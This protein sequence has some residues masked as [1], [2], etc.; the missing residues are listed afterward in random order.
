MQPTVHVFGG[1]SDARALCRT[2]DQA[3][4]AYSL[5]VASEVGKALAQDV[6]G[7]IHV[8][9][10]DAGEMQAWFQRQQIGWVIDAAHPYATALRANIQHACQAL[11]I[12]LLRYQRPSEIDAV[13]HPLITRVTSLAE[14]CKCA[15]E[16]GQRILLTTG[17]KELADYVRLLP[18]KT[19]LARV[20]PTAEVISQCE[21]LGLG[22]ENIIAMKGPFTAQFNQALYQ[23]CQADVVITK[24]S[25]AEGGYQQKIEPC[26]ALGIPCIV[27]ERPASAKTDYYGEV[28]T[29]LNELENYVTRWIN[30]EHL[31]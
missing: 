25:G 31:L 5:S 14:A 18:G 7:Q 22:V 29:S 2:L 11:G 12:P 13:S 6:A 20:L 1:T 28:I 26:I 4:I 24:E 15:G 9:R 21:E 3:A 10:M 16:L 8:G 17:S 30:R 19:L 23:F 27:V